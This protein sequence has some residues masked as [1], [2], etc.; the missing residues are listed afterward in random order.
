M[1]YKVGQII[2]MSNPKSAQIIPLKIVEE[3]IKTTETGKETEY[4]VRFPD[5][6]KTEANIN[7]LKGDVFSSIE[8]IES[9]M[10]DNTTKA[11]KK[12][13]VVAQELKEQAFPSDD[14]KNI[15]QPDIK[16]ETKVN[17]E[18]IPCIDLGNGTKAKIDLESFKKLAQ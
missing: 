14:K 9:F 16:D 4:T 17:K 13:V 18:D 3:I 8:E 5:R 10:I 6:S 12:M 2:F 1:N 7:A 15:A 11:I